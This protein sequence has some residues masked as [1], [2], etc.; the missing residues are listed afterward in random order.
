M[1]ARFVIIRGLRIITLNN[2]IMCGLPDCVLQPVHY[3][4]QLANLFSTVIGQKVNMAARLMM[5]FPNCVTCDETTMSK[6]N[7]PDSQFTMAPPVTLKG[8]SNPENIYTFSTEK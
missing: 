4:S 1:I 2:N 6:S 3:C 7:L 5:K 8:I